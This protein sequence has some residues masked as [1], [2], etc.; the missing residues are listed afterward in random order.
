[1]T[2]TPAGGMILF[3]TTAP[4]HSCCIQYQLTF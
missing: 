3:G 1:M 4:R 2:V